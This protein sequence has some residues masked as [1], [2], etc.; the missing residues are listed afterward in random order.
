[1]DTNSNRNNSDIAP[2]IIIVVE[3]MF[4]I[5]AGRSGLGCSIYQPAA[6]KV[7]SVDITTGSC[8]QLSK[9]W[10]WSFRPQN[11]TLILTTAHVKIPVLAIHVRQGNI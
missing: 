3:G 1:M 8:A 2:I 9:S 10:L 4:C 7:S 5:C 11:S 6:E